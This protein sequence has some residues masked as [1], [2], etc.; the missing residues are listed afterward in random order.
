MVIIDL[1]SFSENVV[2]V[3][4]DVMYGDTGPVVNIDVEEFFKVADFLQVDSQI[5]V[6]T[7]IFRKMMSIE[8]CLE[9][10]NLAG[11]YNFHKL[12]T[13]ALTFIGDHLKEI[14]NS[15]VWK[16]IE[17]ST[18][19]TLI[20]HPLIRCRPDSSVGMALKSYFSEERS[21]DILMATD[22]DMMFQRK[23]EMCFLG[24]FDTTVVRKHI[25]ELT[26]HVELYFV[27]NKELFYIKDTSHRGKILCKYCLHL[28]SFVDIT[29]INGNLGMTPLCE[30]TKKDDYADL[31]ILFVPID[32]GQ[33]KFSLAKLS[34]SDIKMVEKMSFVTT[35]I[36]TTFDVNKV[37]IAADP[38]NGKIYFFNG[39]VIH[40][41]DIE[42]LTFS[43]G[44][45]S[46]NTTKFHI[47]HYYAFQGCVYAIVYDRSK[48]TIHILNETVWS[49]DLYLQQ[50]L[51]INITNLAL[52]TSPT[53][54]AVIVECENDDGL[55]LDYIYKLHP[56]SK[57]LTFFRTSKPKNTYLFVPDH[58]CY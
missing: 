7:T 56:E 6:V 35:H 40:I 32:A 34:V 48:V 18:L 14:M 38:I 39:P 37:D 22:F 3:F 29:A 8:N 20:K 33:R 9:L 36:T 51:E 26:D 1:H 52:C 50:D 45:M 47:V 4:L 15:E 28:K 41:Y 55:D 30:L 2:R 27:F 42:S 49:W 10:Y 12:S 17:E 54:L 11:A 16:R 23:N 19:F 43:E 57:T 25:L 44:N 5:E 24:E 58:I 13:I 53:E 46:P 21:S 31:T